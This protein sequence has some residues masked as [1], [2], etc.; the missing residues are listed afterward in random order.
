M[1]KFLALLLVLTVISAFAVPFASADWA[2]DGPVTLI[3]SYK[4]GNGTDVTARVLAQYAEKYVGQTIVIENVDGGSGSIGWSQLAGS[5]PDGMTIG[6][7]NLPNFNSSIVNELGTYTIDDFTPIC[8]HVTETSIV[9]VR[10]DDDRFNTLEDLVNYCKENVTCASTNG[11]QASNH[12]GAEAFAR[13]AGIEDYID[14]P[15]GNTADE[16]LSL[17]GGEADWC[18]VKVADIASMMSEVKVLGAFSTEPLKE[19]GFEDVPLLKDLGYYEDWLGSSRMIC[20]PAGVSEEVVKFYADAF[21]AAMEDP[22]YLEAAASFTTDYKGPEAS[23]ELFAQQQTFTES[24][25]DGFWY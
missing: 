13:S 14:L 3:V 6:F 12:I 11:A 20:A 19:A 8:N 7:V 5:A 17:R 15:Q 23:A 16:L 24:L 25:A 21:K 2:P 18:V 22:E 4:A 1:K 9:V 10:A